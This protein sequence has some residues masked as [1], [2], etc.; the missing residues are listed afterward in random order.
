MEQFTALTN[1]RGLYKK[2]LKEGSGPYPKEMKNVNIDYIGV[3]ENGVK[4][5]EDQN[6]SFRL[7]AGEVISGWEYGVS[8]MK[9]G[10]K[11]IFVIRHDYAYGAEGQQKVPSYATVVFQIDLN[12]FE[13]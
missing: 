13:S 6:V 4:F 2:M 7:G 11:S 8:T 12:D 3:L 1:D 10:E 5:V 9:K